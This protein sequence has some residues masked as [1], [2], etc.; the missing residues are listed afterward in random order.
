MPVS[1][2]WRRFFISTMPC[3]LAALPIVVSVTISEA[4]AQC[5]RG[6]HP[7]RGVCVRNG[8]F[9]CTRRI[10]CKKGTRCVRG[11]CLPRGANL[12]PGKA[13]RKGLYCKGGAICAVHPET[14]ELKCFKKTELQVLKKT[15]SLKKA[16]HLR[17]VADLSKVSKNCNARAGVV[18]K[19]LGKRSLRLVK[20]TR[21]GWAILQEVDAWL[22]PSACLAAD[23]TAHLIV[24]RNPQGW[25]LHLAAIIPENTPNKGLIKTDTDDGSLKIDRTMARVQTVAL[26]S[27]EQTQIS[28]GGF[29]GLKISSAFLAS[30]KKGKEARFIFSP[31]SKNRLE[32]VALKGSGQ[33]L[34]ACERMKLDAG[35]SPPSDESYLNAAGEYWYF[36]AKNFDNAATVYDRLI[37]VV[38]S[39]NYTYWFR[40]A[41]ALGELGKH[42]E[43]KQAYERTI[44]IRPSAVAYNNLG[45][46]EKELGNLDAAERAYLKAIELEADYLLPVRNLG[47]L[48]KQRALAL[49]EKDKLDK[50]AR[51][52]VQDHLRR[53][54]ELFN[55]VIA[56]KAEGKENREDQRIAKREL[57]SLKPAS[58]AVT[59]IERKQAQAAMA[60]FSDS[61]MKERDIAAILK[62]GKAL[63]KAGQHAVAVQFLR[64]AVRLLPDEDADLWFHLAYN[65][66][67]QGQAQKAVN[68]YTRSIRLRDTTASRNNRAMQLRKLGR[69]QEALTDL[70]EAV[71]KH[72][73]DPLFLNNLAETALLLNKPDMARTALQTLASL[74]TGYDGQ[75]DWR[76]DAARWRL[77]SLPLRIWICERMEKPAECLQAYRKEVEKQ[78][79]EHK[80][81]GVIGIDINDQE[82]KVLVDGIK[83]GLP[84]QAAGIRKGDVII[85]VAGKPV[86]R[87]KDMQQVVFPSIGKALNIVIERNGQRM[88]KTITP[89]AFSNDW[90]AAALHRN[91]GMVLQRLGKDDDA[92]KWLWMAFLEGEKD[93]RWAISMSMTLAEGVPWDIF[94]VSESQGITALELANLLEHKGQAHLAARV[95]NLAPMNLLHNVLTG[96]WFDKALDGQFAGWPVAWLSKGIFLLQSGQNILQNKGKKEVAHTLLRKSLAQLEKWSKRH[97]DDT[98]GANWQADAQKSLKDWAGAAATF[99]KLAQIEPENQDWRRQQIDMLIRAGQLETAGRLLE[100]ALEE[101]KDDWRSWRLKH[102]LESARK[103]FPE[104]AQALQKALSLLPEKSGQR[105]PLSLELA[106]AWMLANDH[107]KALAALE[108]LLNGDNDYYQAKAL[109]TKGEI[110]Q[111][112]GDRDGARDAW[113]RI[114]EAQESIEGYSDGK[115]IVALARDNIAMLDPMK[116]ARIMWKRDKPKKALE[117]LK[118][119]LASHPEDGEALLLKGRI[120]ASLGRHAEAA[121]VFTQYTVLKPAD[122]KGWQE[123]AFASGMA[124]KEEDAKANFER[125]LAL[126][127]SVDEKRDVLL[128]LGHMYMERQEGGKV[129]AA[130]Q[131]LLALE[132][133]GKKPLQND[134]HGLYHVA[135]GFLIEKRYDQARKYAQKTLEAARPGKEREADRFV[136]LA[137]KLLD[138]L[139]P[140]AMARKLLKDDPQA[141]LVMIGKALKQKPQDTHLQLQHAEVLLRLGK[142]EEASKRMFQYT[143]KHPSDAKGWH[144]LAFS[145]YLAGNLNQAV[146]N[147]SRAIALLPGTDPQGKTW[148]GERAWYLFRMGKLDRA[149]KDVNAALQLLPRFAAFLNTRAH[150]YQAQGKPEEALAD[151]QQAME[152]GNADSPVTLLGLAQVL[153]K[154]GKVAKARKHLEKAASVKLGKYAAPDYAQA[155]E[156]A[157]KLLQEW[158]P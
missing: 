36:T 87:A 60:L 113:K 143:I 82:E 3:L 41:Y 121:E 75:R 52:K 107:D 119:V 63:Q 94:A 132:M 55:K 110:L 109:L 76:S 59:L 141:A 44:R 131:R 1:R 144:L 29:T 56:A 116:R 67:E 53:A 42:E 12:C 130:G 106:K 74:P 122:W 2:I 99:A 157:R 40:L 73:K 10:A 68:A 77:L 50:E 145:N 47:Q 54:S 112:R 65:L 126:A 32:K 64:K 153:H 19:W 83:P 62:V 129:R 138:E 92:L 97:P 24:E 13:G 9:Y 4:R 30:L 16:M 134:P 117:A 120:L 95:I 152:N 57:E 137:Q 58:L 37:K 20:C 155:Q 151:Y 114:I 158:K 48:E 11:Q 105:L 148:K 85:S 135:Q 61:V 124:G 127:Q 86:K 149:M 21:T 100:A 150:I 28:F 139:D 108:P 22:R 128:A 51:R 27:G 31:A 70:Q 49:L 66:A 111:A 18:M 96:S 103:H 39:S 25:Q 14:R 90:R 101:H 80:F 154:L 5:A 81:K 140:V 88:E 79:G 71:R 91:L 35:K 123:L 147:I 136:K 146:A 102:Q 115:E 45:V 23:P 133:G 15:V 118:E 43:S 72:P 6:Y 46:Q 142:M 26:Q 125:A 89:V 17:E 93:A 34:Q 104:A 98:I 78:L 84:A 33:A 156:K 38:D 8:Y 7:E 69:L